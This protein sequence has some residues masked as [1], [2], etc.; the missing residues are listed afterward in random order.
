MRSKENSSKPNIFKAKV[1]ETN[2]DECFAIVQDE[3]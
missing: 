3:G 1:E 2:E